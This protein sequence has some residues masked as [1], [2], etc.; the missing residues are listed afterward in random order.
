RAFPSPTEYLSDWPV[1]C[2][3]VFPHFLRLAKSQAHCATNLGLFKIRTDFASFQNFVVGF[4]SRSSHDPSMKIATIIARVLLGLIFVVFGSNIFLHFI[5]MPPP[6]PGLVGDFTKALFLSH[7]LHVVA[8]F[9]IVGGCDAGPDPYDYLLASLGVCTS[10]TV[11]L[12]ARRKKFPLENITVSLSHSRIYAI[13]CEECETK[14]GMLDRIDVEVELTGPLSEAQHAKLM[15]IAAK[16]PVHQTLTSEINI[17][18]RPAPTMSASR[19][20][21]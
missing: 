19:P 20:P 11:G 5:P 9:Q 18:L 15:E 21:L 16:C 6:S 14:E 7:Y 17:R 3:L 8:V 12:Y 2:R 13:D 4:P 10:M 1:R